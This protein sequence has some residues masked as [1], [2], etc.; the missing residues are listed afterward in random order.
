MSSTDTTTRPYL[1]QEEVDEICDPIKQGAAQIRYLRQVLKIKVERKP[2]GRPL[3]WRADV[4]RRRAEP[5]G[6]HATVRASNEPK[7]SRKA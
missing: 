7:W 4:E 2:N 3:V 1:S 6:E 5:S